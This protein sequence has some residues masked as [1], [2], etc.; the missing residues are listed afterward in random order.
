MTLD[1]FAKLDEAALS[2]LIAGYRFVLARIAEQAS[3]RGALWVEE[4]R[5][6][7]AAYMSEPASADAGRR[8]YRSLRDPRYARRSRLIFGPPSRASGGDASDGCAVPASPGGCADAVCVEAVG[9][10]L[11]CPAAPAELPH[12]ET[13]VLGK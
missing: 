9:D 12:V 4:R 6:E 8:S 13:H 1:E 3:D 11:Q 7:L 2:E 10:P 5:L